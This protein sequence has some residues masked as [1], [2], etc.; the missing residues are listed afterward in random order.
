L[1]AGWCNQYQSMLFDAAWCW[2][3][4]MNKVQ[5]HQQISAGILQSMI[6]WSHCKKQVGLHRRA[7]PRDP[8]LNSAHQGAL[9]NLSIAGYCR[10]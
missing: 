3:T 6:A 1:G 9:F 5:H 4:V 10:H 8:G 7:L 2:L